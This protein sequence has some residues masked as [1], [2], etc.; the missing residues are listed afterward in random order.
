MMHQH[1]KGGGSVSCH[2]LCINLPIVDMAGEKK[3]KSNMFM[4]SAM[5]LQHGSFCLSQTTI[6]MASPSMAS[7]D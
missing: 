4:S 3:T 1:K 6:D 5:L 7:F 2:I